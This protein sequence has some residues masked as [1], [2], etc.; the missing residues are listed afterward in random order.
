MANDDSAQEIHYVIS[1]SKNIIRGILQNNFFK[2]AYKQK[3]YLY[4]LYIS[5]YLIIICISIM[6]IMTMSKKVYV[7]AMIFSNRVLDIKTKYMYAFVNVKNVLS[8]V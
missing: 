5:L 1:I 2:N 8:S 7:M 6:N 4:I 3:Y